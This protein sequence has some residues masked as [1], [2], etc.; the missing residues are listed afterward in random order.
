M[1]SKAPE[2]QFDTVGGHYDSIIRQGALLAKDRLTT[3]F[4]DEC[5]LVDYNIVSSPHIGDY[6]ET[7]WRDL[8]VLA[9]S[10]GGTGFFSGMRFPQRC[11]YEVLR[12]NTTLEVNHKE[13]TR[14]V[15][16][17]VAVN[18]ATCT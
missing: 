17:R 5:R 6:I 1:K 12:R 4:E 15:K 14:F 8:D 11:G 18:L 3:Y 10:A 2:M 7:C 9:W 16:M 13:S